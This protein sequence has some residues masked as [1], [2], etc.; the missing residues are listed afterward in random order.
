MK[1]LSLEEIELGC[2][3]ALANQLYCVILY[4]EN[5]IVSL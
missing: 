1:E 2:A 5:D 3:K 4:L